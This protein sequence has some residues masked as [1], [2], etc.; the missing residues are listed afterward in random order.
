M[1]FKSQKLSLVFVLSR[2]LLLGLLVVF[3]IMLAFLHNYGS[4][5][6]KSLVNEHLDYIITAQSDNIAQLLWDFE[7]DKIDVSLKNITDDRRIKSARII[8]H[9]SSGESV[10]AEKNWDENV[11]KTSEIKS[12]DLIYINNQGEKRKIGALQ[13]VLDFTSVQNYLKNALIIGISF[14]ILSFSVLILIFFMLIKRATYPITNLSESLIDA[15]Y[16]THKIEKPQYAT[17]E[18]NDL[19]ETLINMQFIMQRQTKEIQSQKALLHTIIENLPLGMTVERANG[20]KEIVIINH[21]YKKLFG[22]NSDTR[23]ED[24]QLLISAI[25]EEKDVE[26]LE[27]LNESV[28]TKAC[29][30][31]VADYSA[32]SSKT[33]FIAKVIKAPIVDE[34]GEVNLLITMVSDETKRHKAHQ[35]TIKAKEEAERANRAK[36]E[37]LAHM[38][39]EL[40]TP[41]NSIIGFTNIVV[42]E[43]QLSKE[44]LGMMTTIQKSSNLL[45]NIVN[46]ILDLS[47]IETGGITL[48]SIPF[49]FNENVNLV[50]DTMLPPASAKSLLIELDIPD[51]EIGLV[52]GDPTRFTRVLTNLCSNAIKFTEEG[53]VK[54]FIN[55]NMI[56]NKNVEITFS[57]TDTGIGIPANKLDHIFEKFSQAD[58]TITRKYGG[59]GLGLTITKQLVELM[60]GGI[61]VES[62]LGK[63]STFMIQL[64]FK[65]VSTSAQ[66]VDKATDKLVSKNNKSVTNIQDAKIL[67]AED[68]KMN[69]L[70][71]KKLMQRSEIE[72]FDITED[73]ALA[74]DAFKNANFS[75]DLVILDC[76]MPNMTGYEAAENIRKLEREKN[77]ER[78]PIIAITADA[79]IGTY[80]KC[81]NAGMDDYL[82]KPINEKEFK[83]ALTK[84]LNYSHLR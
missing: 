2:A 78:V 6:L 60:G 10:F 71:L 27:C 51:N 24:N 76:H 73:G 75:Y 33:P 59:T 21:K 62:E 67:I 38:S 41:M 8:E 45:L 12:Q 83:T 30:K 28:L 18:I 43:A 70:L 19:F 13:V 82:T 26:F 50:V 53:S 47:K 58:D 84:W 40:R 14:F 77:A 48:E 57:V 11:A 35:D 79:M 31:E 22:L 66:V 69:Q 56:D 61:H 49:N 39:H 72:N 65:K 15:D 29:V 68:Q 36:S 5:I 54:I 74:L 52:L 34:N 80:D 55:Y 4:Q 46:D 32:N 16:F 17:K 23:C 81:I 20:S 25:H 37:F 64:P 3:T 42:D 1:P 7:I 44:N 9:S 63:G